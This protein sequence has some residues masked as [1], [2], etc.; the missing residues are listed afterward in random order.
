[1]PA[2]RG[3]KPGFVA[4]LV[5][6]LRPWTWVKLATQAAA[7]L[8]AYATGHRIL[9]VT[10]PLATT[11]RVARRV[12]PPGHAALDHRHHE[13]HHLIDGIDGLASA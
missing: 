8:V 4:G 10:N 6:D 2:L 13:R 7:G 11:T 9:L 1:L 3:R 5:D 12:E